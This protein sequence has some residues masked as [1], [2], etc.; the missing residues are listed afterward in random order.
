MDNETIEWA[1]MMKRYRRRRDQSTSKKSSSE[2]AMEDGSRAARH[3]TI[4]VVKNDM[5]SKF[6]GILIS[7]KAD[8]ESEC[9]YYHSAA[10]S[11][12]I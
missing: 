6:L 8:I 2:L 10:V 9:T 5:K 12:I 3:N 4:T 11:N 7:V 1:I